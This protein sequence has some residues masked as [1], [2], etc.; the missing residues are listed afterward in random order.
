MTSPNPDR[1]HADVLPAQEC[2]AYL[3]GESVG[4]LGVTVDEVPQIFPINYVV[5]HGS[6]VFRTGPGTKLEALL[7]GRQV[8]LEADGVDQ[9]TGAA[10]SVMA[11]ARAEPIT[12]IEDVLDSAALELFPWQPGQKDNFIRLLVG[13]ISGRRFSVSP[14]STWRDGIDDTPRAGH[15]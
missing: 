3:R 5:D 12:G 6:L 2:W 14:A 11:T 1:P 10:W 15:E 8:A 13:G 4:R 7:S 9:V